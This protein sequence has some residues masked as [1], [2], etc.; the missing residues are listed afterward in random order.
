MPKARPS[1]RI[2]ATPKADGVPTRGIVASRWFRSLRSPQETADHLN[3]PMEACLV[4]WGVRRVVDGPATQILRMRGGH[5]LD[6][7]HPRL[8]RLVLDRLEALGTQ[9]G[10]NRRVAK[11]WPSLKSLRSGRLDITRDGHD[12][13]KAPSRSMNQ[14]V[15]SVPIA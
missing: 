13:L 1:R 14:T 4:T 3:A 9:A 7:D 5:H 8:V 6:V 2:V 11:A 12:R 10:S 15:A